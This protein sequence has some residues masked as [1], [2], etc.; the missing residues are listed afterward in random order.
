MC[1]WRSRDRE[2][3]YKEKAWPRRT[4]FQP[5]PNNIIGNSRIDPKKSIT[6]YSPHKTWSNKTVDQSSKGEG[7]C[8]EH[9]RGKF[10]KFPNAKLKEGI[11]DGPQIRKM[12]NDEYFITLMNQK[13]KAACISF[14]QVLENILE[15]HKSRGYKKIVAGMVKIFDEVG[16]LM[17][18]KLRFLFSHLD[19]FTISLGDNSEEQGERFH[20]DIKEIEFCQTLK[21]EKN[22]K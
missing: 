9:L 11:I 18:L 14:M 17:N 7:S 6:S 22:D 13:Q 3:H 20:K 15:N 19:Y 5:D 1:L 21:E 4:S 10:Q 16:C 12:L 8:L 2:N